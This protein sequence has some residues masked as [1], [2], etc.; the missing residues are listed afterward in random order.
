MMPWRNGTW[1]ACFLVI[2]TEAG[3]FAWNRRRICA[4][5]GLVSGTA[6]GVFDS[7]DGKRHLVLSAGLGNTEVIPR[8]NNIPEIVCVDL[9]PEGGW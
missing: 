3:H 6:E 9:V 7:K 8:F 5:Y 2:F 1:T 4:G